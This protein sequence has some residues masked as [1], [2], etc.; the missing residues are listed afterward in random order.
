MESLFMRLIKVIFGNDEILFVK[1]LDW[2]A[3]PVACKAV[4]FAG[5]DNERLDALNQFQC[6]CIVKVLLVFLNTQPYFFEN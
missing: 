4:D 2:A 5:F 6:Q 1:S 3:V